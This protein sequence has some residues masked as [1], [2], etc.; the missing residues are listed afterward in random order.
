[1]AWES[2]PSLDWMRARVRLASPSPMALKFNGVFSVGDV[3]T[4]HPN[5]AHEELLTT[6]LSFVYITVT[7]SQKV[8]R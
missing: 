3:E 5:Q 4:L 2:T 8:L 6:F 7:G 1:M